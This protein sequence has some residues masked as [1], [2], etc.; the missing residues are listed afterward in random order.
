MA[1]LG[2]ELQTAPGLLSGRGEE[3]QTA[4][5][6]PGMG[7]GSAGAQRTQVGRSLALAA[8][9]PAPPLPQQDEPIKTLPCP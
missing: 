6:Q 8:R 5:P 2:A 7:V 3:P 4:C 1:R 9:V